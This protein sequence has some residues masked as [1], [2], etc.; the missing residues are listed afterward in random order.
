MKFTLILLALFF[1][2]NAFANAGACS[3]FIPIIGNTEFVEVDGVCLID[4]ETSL[5]D[6]VFEG[7]TL[8]YS[9][10]LNLLF[11]ILV[12][13]GKRAALIP[14]D[15]LYVLE[16]G[17]EGHAKQFA[18]AF[19]KALGFDEFGDAEIGPI[20]GKTIEKLNNERRKNKRLREENRQ[21]REKN[22]AF[23]DRE[24][25]AELKRFEEKIIESQESGDE[26]GEIGIP[27]DV[28]QSS[29][30]MVGLINSP[31]VN[32][33][34]LGIEM[35]LRA[36]KRENRLLRKLNG[37]SKGRKVKWHSQGSYQLK[38]HS[39]MNEGQY[40]QS[41]NGRYKFVMQGDGN[42]V[43]YSGEKAIWSSG[44]SGKGK[45]PYKLKMQRDGNLVIYGMGKAIWST[46]T[47]KKG[48]GPYRLVMQS[49]RNVVLYDK[50]GKALWS[51]GTWNH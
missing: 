28:D 29:G 33:N 23:R 37:Y 41:N 10:D 31:D 35:L 48:R 34:I 32:K 40:L 36:Y 42:L 8:R 26:E 3:T 25:A 18:K 21:L 49:D 51:T 11:T 1:S 5:N 44:T 14:N 12:N 17:N 39:W 19:W 43:M 16:P 46:R 24:T 6:L 22:E 47:N 7:S 30:E 9:E 38:S 4:E 50:L 2:T 13:G 15:I 27:I 45:Y 20:H